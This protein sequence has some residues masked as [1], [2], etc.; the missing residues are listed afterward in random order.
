MRHKKRGRKLGRSPSHQRALLRNLASA[1]ILTERDPELF[2]SKDPKA[3]KPPKVPGRI[4]TT[5]QKAKEVRPLLERCITIARRALPH[6]EAAEDLEPDADRDSPQWRAWRESQRWQE[7]N[8]AIAPA[9]AARRRALKLLGDKEAVQILFEEIAPRLEDRDG[10]YTR[11]LRLA[12]PRLGDAGTRAILELVGSHDRV[13]RRT[14]KPSYKDE[15]LEADVREV[16]PSADE[17]AAQPE[18]EAETEAAAE[19]GEAPSEEAEEE[20][21]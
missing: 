12:K 1:L 6:Q 5:L 20:K 10:G 16:A 19:H 7:W 15:L 13:R 4:V 17:A 9:V 2:D 11:V 14:P 3:P 18:A 21:N 8:Q